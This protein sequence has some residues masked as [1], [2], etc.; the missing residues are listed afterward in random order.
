MALLC[1]FTC[2]LFSPFFDKTKDDNDKVIYA[3][4][5]TDI[6]RDV[7]FDNKPDGE[8]EI[9]M[10]DQLRRILG[11]A[12]VSRREIL[13]NLID[14]LSA[15]MSDVEKCKNLA[16]D[17]LIHQWHLFEDVDDMEHQ[18]MLCNLQSYMAAGIPL[19]NIEE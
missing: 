18:M 15:V 13:I 5:F 2:T 16:S 19:M 1:S 17:I 3:E 11:P 4:I 6:L 9:M 8:I 14:R 7:V 12:L 10:H